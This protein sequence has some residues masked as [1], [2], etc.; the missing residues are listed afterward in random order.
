[1]TVEMETVR[2]AVV[3]AGLMGCGIAHVFAAAGN[4][5]RLYDSDPGALRMVRSRIDAG[6]VELGGSEQIIDLIEPVSSLDAAVG[7]ADVVVEAVIEDLAV[8]RQVFAALDE[9][10]PPSALLATN[11]S[12]ISISAIAES[13]SRPE[14]LLGTHWW[15]PAPLIPLVEV[16]PGA[17]TAP[18][19]VERMVSLLSAV[20]K[21]PVRLKRDVPGFIGNRMQHALWREAFAIVEAGIAEPEDVDEVVKASFGARLAVL[22]PIENADLVGLDMTKAIHDYLLPHLDAGVSASR[23][24]S[25]RVAQGELGMKT[26]RGL[27]SW[28]AEE[29]DAVR[30]RLVRHLR[31]ASIGGQ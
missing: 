26:G 24:V 29:A 10:A 11:T 9:L 30:A 2:V 1:M 12:V 15:N 27:R 25:D 16:V 14:R 8:K 20:G 22:G 6:V 18:E 19:A 5:V 28:T 7:G 13:T 21:R 4:N 17:H 3:G 23:I 31:R